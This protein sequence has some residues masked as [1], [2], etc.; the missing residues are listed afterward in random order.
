[1]LYFKG[2]KFSSKTVMKKLNVP[3]DVKAL[4]ELLGI[5]VIAAIHFH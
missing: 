1:M 4:Y 2:L 5:A 3:S